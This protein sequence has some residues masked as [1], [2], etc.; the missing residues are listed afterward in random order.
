MIA[1]RV[2]VTPKRLEIAKSTAIIPR[3]VRDGDFAART[4]KSPS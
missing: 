2:G 3:E 1:H 4:A